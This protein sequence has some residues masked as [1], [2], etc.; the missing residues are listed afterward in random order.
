M[1]RH[2]NQHRS[3]HTNDDGEIVSEPFPLNIK[4]DAKKAMS[5]RLGIKY[6][7]ISNNEAPKNNWYIGAHINSNFGEADFPEF[8]L[9]YVYQINYKQL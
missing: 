4:Y 6:Y 3:R 7:W 9:G 5:G 8:T 2:T 1:N